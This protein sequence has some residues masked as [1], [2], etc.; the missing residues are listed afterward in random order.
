MT[1]VLARLR[2]F[3][4]TGAYVGLALLV[5]GAAE[6][7]VAAADFN[8]T[9]NGQRLEADSLE[10]DEITVRLLAL[11][12]AADAAV[13]AGLAQDHLP[14]IIEPIAVAPDT[15]R[16]VRASRAPPSSPAP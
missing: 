10:A 13:P 15:A 8:A 6:R 4:R 11:N 12:D 5:C 14:I 7:P 9:P 1:S 16:I 2:R 3:C